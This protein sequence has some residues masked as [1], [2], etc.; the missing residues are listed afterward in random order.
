[1]GFFGAYRTILI[2]GQP[3]KQVIMTP[4]QPQPQPQAPQPQG[5]PLPRTLQLPSEPVPSSLLAGSPG[6][7]I[8]PKQQPQQVTLQAG[9]ANNPQAQRPKT[10]VLREDGTVT[11]GQLPIG[12]KIII[13]VSILHLHPF[14]LL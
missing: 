5:T 14:L 3:S 8:K 12:Q 13:Q 11:G 2:P 1:M 6:P 10:V 9:A 4:I 7:F